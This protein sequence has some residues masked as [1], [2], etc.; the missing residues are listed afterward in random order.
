VLK[1][2]ACDGC[3]RCIEACTGKIDIRDVLK[4]ALDETKSL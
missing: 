4:K 1:K 2:Y 3:G